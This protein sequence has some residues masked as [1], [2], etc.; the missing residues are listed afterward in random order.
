M[1]N[2]SC[3]FADDDSHNQ[4]N[5]ASKNGAELQVISADTAILRAH[6]ID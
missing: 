3:G 5:Q 1:L 4:K 2:Q 6:L